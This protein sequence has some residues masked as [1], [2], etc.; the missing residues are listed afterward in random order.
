M[1]H[2]PNPPTA[3]VEPLGDVG[4]RIGGRLHNFVHVRVRQASVAEPGQDR[5]G[6]RAGGDLGEIERGILERLAVGC[7]NVRV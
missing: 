6:H 2:N 7:Q 1:P 3:S 4:D 5:F